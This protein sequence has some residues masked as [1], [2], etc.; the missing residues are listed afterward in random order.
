MV[1]SVSGSLLGGIGG[2]P[3]WVSTLCPGRDGDSGSNGRGRNELVDGV[4][5]GVVTD[6][7]KCIVNYLCKYIELLN[8]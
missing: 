1:G 2:P 6:Q 5:L 4:G 7:I 3:L 8:N